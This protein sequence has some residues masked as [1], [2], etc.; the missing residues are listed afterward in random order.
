M[1]LPPYLANGGQRPSLHV[2]AGLVPLKRP[3]IILLSAIA[4]WFLMSFGM[5]GSF[6]MVEDLN[7]SI[8]ATLG[9]AIAWV[10]LPLGFG[11]QPSAVATITGLIAKEKRSQHLW[12]GLWRL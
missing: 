1:E 7:N 9:N 4:L 12:C 5:E 11:K 3:D 10:F 8:L 6:G 2:G